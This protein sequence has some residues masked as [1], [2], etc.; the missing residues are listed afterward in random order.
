MMWCVLWWIVRAVVVGEWGGFCRGKDAVWQKRLAA[1]LKQTGMT[2]NFY[3]V[4][5]DVIYVW[6]FVLG[7]A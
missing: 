3:W 7:H 6:A 2:D 1:Y 4:C 5:I